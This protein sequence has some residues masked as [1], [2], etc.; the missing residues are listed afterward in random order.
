MPGTRL[1]VGR[2]IARVH[3]GDRGHHGWP[4][5]GEKSADP[6]PPAGQGRLSRGRGA[7]GQIGTDN[8]LAHEHR[9]CG[10]DEALAI[11]CTFHHRV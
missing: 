6:A 10:T 7:I 5:K 1:D 2:E 3:V 9:Q 11:N 8:R 4:D